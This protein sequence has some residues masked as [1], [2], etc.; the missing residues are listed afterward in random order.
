M[1]TN[2]ATIFV[3]I[4]SIII[5]VL[6]STS[7][8]FRKINNMVFL[9][10]AEYQE[11]YENTSKLNNDISKLSK[12]Y[13]E[14]YNK[15]QSYKNNENENNLLSEVNK[16]IAN[17]EMILGYT[18][19]EGEGVVI[20]LDDGT[21][22]AQGEVVDPNDWWA[23]TVHDNDVVN[24]IND[25]KMAGAEAISI[26]GQRLTDKSNI[27]CWGV[28]IELD[29]V[30]IPAPFNIKAIGDKEKIFSYMIAEG[31]YLS[32]L[33]IRGIHL[34]IYRQDKIQILGN[35]KKITYTY[36]KEIKEK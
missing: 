20:E 31:G 32:F 6:I 2:E 15:L 18:D 30:K 22:E 11:A 13:D 34:N 1:K 23:K 4:A 36:M 9:T 16:E 26:N 3:F 33:K 28:F 24:V 29:G 27:L 12:K 21:E 35:D 10:P 25:L 5:G 19:I 17:N 14:Y 8:N 7:I